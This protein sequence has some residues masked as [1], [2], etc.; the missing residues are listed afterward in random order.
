ML[1]R[2]HFLHGLGLAG[3]AFCARERMFSS[4][5]P[6]GVLSEFGYGD[7]ELAPGHPQSQFEQTRSVLLG[8]N[9]DSLLKPWRLRAGC[10]H[11]AR[12]WEGGT[13]RLLQCNPEWR[14]WICAC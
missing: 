8:V 11:P 14:E 2:R 3:V 10:R 12:I 9:E 13:T 6:L 4:E 5:A 1:S 7:V